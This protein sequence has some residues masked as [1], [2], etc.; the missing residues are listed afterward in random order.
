MISLDR[1]YISGPMSALPR[2]QYIQRFLYAEEL[3]RKEGYVNIVNPIRVWSCR[4]PWLYKIVGYR[5]TLLYDLF[6]LM[7]C[8]RIYKLPDWRNSHGASIESCVAYHFNIFLLARPVRDA[9]DQ[10]METMIKEQ[11]DASASS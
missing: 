9:L 1:I 4:W 5:L 3:L 10:L 6:L 8:Q 7:R 2:E 11:G